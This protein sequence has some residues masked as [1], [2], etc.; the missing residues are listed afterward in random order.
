MTK[1]LV[2][3]RERN[4]DLLERL[5]D[6]GIELEFAQLPVGDY[7]VSDRICVE[8]K[9]MRDFSSSIINS[10]LFDQLER[11]RSSFAK[12]VL[13]VEGDDSEFALSQNVLLGAIVSAYVDYG[14]MVIR[15]AGP[16]Q[17]AEILAKMAEHEQKQKDREPMRVG[18]KRAYTISEWQILM[19]SS[20]PGIGQKLAHSLIKNFKS[21]RSVASASVDELMKV[22]KI[23][24]KKAEL[25]HRVMNEEFDEQ[26]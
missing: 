4:L 7:I 15:S 26:N 3:N 6:M 14:V 24:R 19:L 23:G 16:E 8:R 17:T 1:V 22:E 18:I 20:L 25:V 13:I 21:V 10:R 12:P 11:L 9:A 2:D 5:S